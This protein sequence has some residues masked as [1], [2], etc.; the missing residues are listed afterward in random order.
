MI[1]KNILKLLLCAPL[2]SFGQGAPAPY[3]ALPS[4]RQLAWHEMEM[5]CLIHYTPTTFQDKEW[6]FGDAD[7]KIFNP[8]HFDANQI[9]K[10]A[11]SA[12]FRGLISVAKHHDGFCLWPTKTNNYNI[13]QSLWKEG[14]G[15]MVK[16]FMMASHAQG[17]A[18]GVYLSAWDRNDTRYGTAAYA[19]AYRAQLTELMTGYGE[20]FTSWHDGANGGDGYYGGKNEK[21]TIDRTTYYAWEEKTWPIVRRY[22]PKA[23]IFSDIG[24]D[25]RWVG[26]EHGFAAET[27]WA[28]I[29]PRTKDGSKPVPGQLDDSNLTTGDRDGKFWIPAE[30]DVPQ[31]PGWFYHKNQDG[32]VKTPKQLFEI[33]L[34]SVGRGANMNLGL[35][36]MPEGVLHDNDVQSLAAFGRKLERTFAK[37]LAEGAGATVSSVRGSSREFAVDNLFDDDRYTYYAPEEG[38]FNPVIEISL[39]ERVTFDIIRLRENI[40]LGQR[41]DSVVVSVFNGSTWQRLASATSIGANRLIKLDQPIE[42]SKLKIQLFAPVVPTLSDI[43]LFKE[44]EESFSFEQA[45]T[46]LNKLGNSAYTLLSR[47]FQ[48]AF[49]GDTDSFASLSTV[50]SEV[51]LQLNETIRALGYVPRQDGEK[52]GMVTKYTIYQSQDGKKWQLIKEGEFSNIKSNPTEQIITFDTLQ[53]GSYLKFVP[54]ETINRTFTVA[55]FNLYL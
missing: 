48:K 21:R 40:K 19:D 14:K 11:A 16:E 35:A 4:P 46:D 29:T 36:P 22:Q 26:N 38:V 32:K 39:P 47:T 6:G 13:A 44:Y 45:A 5:Y 53:P 25:M 10:A 8:S 2:L 23:M 30:C 49:D 15:D 52:E 7:P 1:L 54:K 28:T 50:K 17:M 27:S 20:L 43:G 24:P 55:E 42:T 3:G 37:N 12:G 9:A 41:L 51:I 18:F 33:Y 31:R 34:K